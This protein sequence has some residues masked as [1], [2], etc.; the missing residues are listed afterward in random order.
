MMLSGTES[1]P[2]VLLVDETKRCIAAQEV[3][4]AAGYTVV[5]AETLE[6]FAEAVR[7]DDERKIVAFINPYSPALAGG[8]AIFSY[9]KLLENRLI[10]YVWTDW[11]EQDKEVEA[12]TLEQTH[13]KGALWAINKK[14]KPKT[15]LTIA[16][17]P[18]VW[19]LKERSSKDFLTQLDTRG[20][21]YQAMTA[22]VDSASRYSYPEHIAVV[23]IDVNQF[24]EINDVHGHAKGDEVLVMVADSM[25]AIFGRAS[26]HR[27]RPGGDEFWV[28]MIET[29]AQ[30]E[31]RA[32]KLQR[33]IS[34]TAIFGVKGERIK[35][36]VSCGVFQLTQNDICERVAA[37]FPI[38]EIVEELIN[39]AD[40]D[41]KKAKDKFHGR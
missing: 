24:K 36:S 11:D 10:T 38:Q 33:L 3:F 29:Q 14:S 17:W 20:S 23:V 40:F 25:R 7:E 5:I 37:R 19:A 6:Q 35:V 21:F 8:G 16:K 22:L 1:L 18:Y 34:E 15:L 13:I 30:A 39:V 31:A 12:Y 27:C 2:V 32:E 41:Q 26:E 4:Q 28:G 9:T